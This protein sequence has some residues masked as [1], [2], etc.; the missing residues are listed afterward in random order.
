MNTYDVDVLSTRVGGY[1]EFRVSF[2]T[3]DR[4]SLVVVMWFITLF[5]LLE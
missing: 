4:N 5:E 2:E 3:G 1:M